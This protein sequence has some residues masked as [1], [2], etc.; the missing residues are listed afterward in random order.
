VLKEVSLVALS[1]TVSAITVVAAAVALGGGW[2][3]YHT[4]SEQAKQEQA[5]RQTLRLADLSEKQAPDFHLTDQHGK[6]ISLSD[7]KGKAVVLQFMDPVCTDVC[8]IVSQEVIQ[9]NHSLGAKSDDVVYIAVNVNQYHEKPADTLA[10]SK[11]HGLDKLPNWHFVTG[12][13]ASLQAV[14]KAYSVYVKPNPDGD[15]VHSS[16]I[17]FLDKDGKERYVANASD[18][19]SA[20]PGMSKGI[21]FFTNKLI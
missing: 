20:I 14:W 16:F 9:A 13:T 1:K 10:F 19:K 17:Y 6:Q 12:D 5:L 11:E 18:D 15:V 2:Y 4:S 3:W 7:F 21:A 8:P